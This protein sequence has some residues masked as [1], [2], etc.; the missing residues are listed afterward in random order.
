MSHGNHFPG[1]TSVGFDPAGVDLSLLNSGG[2]PVFDNHNASA[3]AEAQKG[4]VERAWALGGKYYATLRFSRRPAVDGLWLD[5]AGGIVSKFSMGTEILDDHLIGD[6]DHGV[7][8]RLADRWRPFEIS[9]APLPA[10]FGTTTLSARAAIVPEWVAGYQPPPARDPRPAASRLTH[11]SEQTDDFRGAP[12]WP[13][14][15]HAS[16]RAKCFRRT[17]PKFKQGT[18]RKNGKSNSRWQTPPQQC[19]NS[20]VAR[21]NWSQ[22][23]LRPHL[24]SKRPR[25]SLERPCLRET[26]RLPIKFRIY[27]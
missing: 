1:N 27:A 22:C 24:N 2:C 3:G 26:I 19:R 17:G 20:T 14:A 10:D 21:R 12:S 18:E 6:D 11:V 13:M 23:R 4:V 5:I 7:P 9:I 8:I 25:R 16:E 15:A